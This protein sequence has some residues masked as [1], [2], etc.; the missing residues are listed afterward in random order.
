MSFRFT[1]LFQFILFP[2][3]CFAIDVPRGLSNSDRIDV[4]K[5]LGLTTATK[6]LTNPYPLGGYSG[7]EV[8][9]SM[10]VINTRDLQR[11]GTSTNGDQDELRYTRLTIGK[12]LYNDLD[13]FFHLVPPV[14]SVGVSD[15]GAALRW[16]FFQAEFLPIHASLWAYG[17]QI[18]YQNS[19][20]NQNLG[21]DLV[22]GLNVDNFALY[23]GMG[24]VYAKGTFTGGTTGS[25]TVDVGDPGLNTET[26]VTHMDVRSMHSVF[27]CTISFL[28]FFFSG[29]IDRYTDPV[30]SA[31]FGVRY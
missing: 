3:L 13:F 22:L 2:S 15:Y 16:A 10:E 25:G 31:K 1:F 19:F 26:N 7:F 17:N 14:S 9:M 29:Q 24:M 30:Y 20:M 11:L 8:G 27:G 28:D 5:I 12:G 23:F 21:S 6:M 4:T 18:N